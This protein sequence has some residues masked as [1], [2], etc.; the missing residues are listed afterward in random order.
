MQVLCDKTKGRFDG[1][2]E[3]RSVLH[4]SLYKLKWESKMTVECIKGISSTLFV[5]WDIG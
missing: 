2:T 5:S 3:Y 1:E 4:Y